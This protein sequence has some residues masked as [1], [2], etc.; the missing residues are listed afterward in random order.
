MF[1]LFVEL[2]L[3]IA[4]R[5]LFPRHI[6]PLRR[7]LDARNPVQG[8]LRPLLPGHSILLHVPDAFEHDHVILTLL[9]ISICREDVKKPFMFSQNQPV[10]LLMQEEKCMPSATNVVRV[11]NKDAVP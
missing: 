1:V 7:V 3:A 2:K 6:P 4:A 5:V 10:N 8:L 11:F 9:P